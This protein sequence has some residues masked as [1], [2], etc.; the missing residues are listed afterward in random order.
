MMHPLPYFFSFPPVL[1][2]G[3]FFCHVQCLKGHRLF[4][5]IARIST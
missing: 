4:F 2:Q 1:S 3:A 5:D